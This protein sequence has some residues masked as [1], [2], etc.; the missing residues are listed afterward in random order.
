MTKNLSTHLTALLSGAT[1]V[2][3]II[4]P[5]FVIPPF[6]QGLAVVVPSVAAAL[7]EALHFVKTH[8]LQANL[9]AADHVVNQLVANVAKTNDTPAA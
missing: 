4:H 1:S 7:I 8:N 6:V 3:A 9:L 5:G 2:L